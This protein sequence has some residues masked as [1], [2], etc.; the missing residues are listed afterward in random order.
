MTG[1]IVE[2][3]TETDTTVGNTGNLIKI[4]EGKFISVASIHID[5]D[6]ASKF[7][8]TEEIVAG[9]SRPV[10]TIDGDDVILITPEEAK[11]YNAKTPIIDILSKH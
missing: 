7:F 6:T 5:L 8:R 4:S 3:F 1:N 2:K 11:L 9:V 10:V